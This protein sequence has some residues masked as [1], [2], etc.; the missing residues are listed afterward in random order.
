MG[1]DGEVN[2]GAEIEVQL[3]PNVGTASGPNMEAESR[4]H[5]GVELASDIDA[6]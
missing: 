4:F 1:P 3:D 6:G 2:V 5:V